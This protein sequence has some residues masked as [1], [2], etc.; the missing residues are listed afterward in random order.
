MSE[1]AKVNRRSLAPN[2]FL[3]I[4]FLQ[5]KTRKSSQKKLSI[6]S[7]L[8]NPLMSHRSDMNDLTTV[9]TDMDPKGLNR[10]S[11]VDKFSPRQIKADDRTK[12]KKVASQNVALLKDNHNNKSANMLSSK[13]TVNVTRLLMNTQESLKNSDKQSPQYQ[14][15]IKEESEANVNEL[16]I[17]VIP[18]G[19][20]KSLENIAKI[21][22]PRLLEIS[23]IKPLPFEPKISILPLINSSVQSLREKNKLPKLYQP[24][25]I[26]IEKNFLQHSY[27]I[28]MPKIKK[29]KQDCCW[30]FCL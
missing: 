8:P 21:E 14:K 12:I 15:T 5:K 28:K 2:N 29:A 19:I 11:I 16:T 30:A 10:L 20:D 26:P 27:Q 13:S 9:V 24:K 18:S 4:P 1:L 3:E 22:E 7:I 25:P 6:N 23:E 17:R